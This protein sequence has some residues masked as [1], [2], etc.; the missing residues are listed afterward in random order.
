MMGTHPTYGHTGQVVAALASLP[1]ANGMAASREGL[2]DVLQH[3]I[4]ANRIR[5]LMM[6]PILSCEFHRSFGEFRSTQKTRIDLASTR[7]SLAFPGGGC[8]STRSQL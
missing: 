7:G 6:V 4:Q 1:P 2:P 3:I 5:V 8:V